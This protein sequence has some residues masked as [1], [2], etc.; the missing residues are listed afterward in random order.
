MKGLPTGYNKDLQEDK[1]A[2]VRQRGHAG[3]VA[4]RH[5]RGRA[6]PHAPSRPHR[7]AAS[8]LLLA[9]DVADYLVAR[10]VPFRQAHEIVGGMVRTLLA[11]A[12]TSTAC[13][14]TSGGVQPSFR[15]RRAGGDDAGGLGPGAQD[16]AVDRAR[17]RR[18][19][20]R[21]DDAGM[22]GYTDD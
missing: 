1:E 13:R 6:A 19:R 5:A 22:A 9:T 16:A 10:G 14:S 2:G 4:R 20:A 21:G 12:R 7:L 17:R 8:G 15:R 11:K 3:G 18:A